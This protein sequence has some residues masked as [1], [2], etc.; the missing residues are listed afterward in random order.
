MPRGRPYEP[1]GGQHIF[2]GAIDHAGR[3]GSTYGFHTLA[4]RNAYDLRSATGQ[5]RDQHSTYRTGCAP[6]HRN[7]IFDRPDARETSGRQ[8]GD[9]QRCP[10]LETELVGDRRQ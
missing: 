2:A 4:A 1:D 9:G 6:Y 3:A 5:E 10:I 8:T 7:T